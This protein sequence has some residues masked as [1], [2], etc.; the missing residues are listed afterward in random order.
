MADKQ[1]FQ[2]G[3]LVKVK[4]GAFAGRVGAV[5]DPKSAVDARGNPYPATRAGYHWVMLILNDTPFPAHLHQDEIEP[6]ADQAE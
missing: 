1:R 4:H 5:L 3:T 2:P 6:I